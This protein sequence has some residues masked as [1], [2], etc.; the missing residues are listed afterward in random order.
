MSLYLSYFSEVEPIGF[1]DALDVGGEREESGVTPEFFH[2]S[3]WKGGV[4]ID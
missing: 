3:H 2:L 4:A 1:D